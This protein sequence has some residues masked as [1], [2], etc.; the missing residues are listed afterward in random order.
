[1]CGLERRWGGDTVTPYQLDCQGKMYWSK[2]LL[3]LDLEGR[4][5]MS[6][7]SP[8]SCGCCLWVALRFFSFCL[9][10]EDSMRQVLFCCWAPSFHD[11]S[12]ILSLYAEATISTT[13][14]FPL[15]IVCFS[16]RFF[17]WH[18]LLWLSIRLAWELYFGDYCISNMDKM[19]WHK[20]I[21]EMFW[22]YARFC[23]SSVRK[24]GLGGLILTLNLEVLR[25]CLGR[26]FTPRNLVYLRC[27][28][29]EILDLTCLNPG[30][31]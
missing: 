5:R 6:H 16:C 24:L 26:W 15:P 21:T 19:F 3:Q 8:A 23:S 27:Q 4:L 7:F 31:R 12:H 30:Q 28:C 1:M 18:T 22:L 17:D 13:V 11:I 20:E 14:M 9:V 10:Y 29:W 25:C 2:S